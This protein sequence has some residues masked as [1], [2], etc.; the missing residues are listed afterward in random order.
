[1]DLTDGTTI[2][3]LITGFVVLIAVGSVVG[4]AMWHAENE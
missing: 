1:M 3:M 4:Y 2:A